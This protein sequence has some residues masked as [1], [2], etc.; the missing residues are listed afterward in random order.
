MKP[1]GLM[2]SKIPSE[3][4][5]DSTVVLSR[6]LAAAGSAT[7]QSQVSPARKAEG[8]LGHWIGVHTF[9]TGIEWGWGEGS[10]QRVWTRLGPATFLSVGSI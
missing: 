2:L 1:S 7:L 8:T 3:S 6:E 10:S 5:I 4:A 9:N